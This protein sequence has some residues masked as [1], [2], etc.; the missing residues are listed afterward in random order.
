MVRTFC[1]LVALAFAPS[2]ALAQAAPP[3]TDDPRYQ[4]HRAEDGYLRLDL[5]TGQVSLCSR[6]SAGWACLTVP[7]DRAAFDQE[8][9]RLQNENVAMKRALLERG[10]ALPGGVTSAPPVVR[11]G[12]GGAKPL[13]NGDL[14]RMMAA[15]ERAWR[16]LVEMISN[17]HKDLMKKT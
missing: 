17:M 10:L 1:C 14:D 15:V 12:E 13:P 5:R 7:D 8:I 9:A 4:F 11:D 6:H 2:V 3:E 16:R